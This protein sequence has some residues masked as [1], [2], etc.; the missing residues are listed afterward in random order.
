[1]L[2]IEIEIQTLQNTDRIADV[3]ETLAKRIRDGELAGDVL[4]PAG[5][6]IG[7]FALDP[8]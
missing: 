3:L 6:V 2:T 8:S 5:Q 1:M 7:S 4:N